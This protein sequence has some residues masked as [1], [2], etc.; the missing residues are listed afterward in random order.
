MNKL[1]LPYDRDI[2]GTLSEPLTKSPDS[3]QDT[4][5]LLEE[6]LLFDL[7]YIRTCLQH[8]GAFCAGLG[9]RSDFGRRSL[10]RVCIF[11]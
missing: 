3:G 2:N 8:G 7:L 1:R 4:E 9:P 11:F 5:I 10:R 6:K